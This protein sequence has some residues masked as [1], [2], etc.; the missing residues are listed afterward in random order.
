MG[1]HRQSVS[2][3]QRRQLAADTDSIARSIIEQERVA[4]RAK[5]ARL[6]EARFKMEAEASEMPITTK[7]TNH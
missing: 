2:Q 3:E 5:T 1:M 6:R 7:A 4:R